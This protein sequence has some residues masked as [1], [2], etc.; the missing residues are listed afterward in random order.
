VRLFV[1]RLTAVPSEVASSSVDLPDPFSPTKKITFEVILMS[2]PCENAGMLKGYRFRS[3]FSGEIA[4]RRKNGPVRLADVRRN[5]E[6]ILW[7]LVCA[8]YMRA[9]RYWHPT[10]CHSNFGNS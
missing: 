6:F 4:I 3:I 9:L 5:V 1:E 7:K 10:I 2:I 8:H